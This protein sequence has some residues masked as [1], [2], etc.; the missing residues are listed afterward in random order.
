MVP[1][2]IRPIW[3]DFSCLCYHIVVT[4]QLDLENLFLFITRFGGTTITII[5]FL[6]V[7]YLLWS[8]DRT[9]I[10]YFITLFICNETLVYIIKKV[11]GRERPLGA[12]KYS[13]FGASMP[14]GHAAVAVFLYGYICYLINRFYPKSLWRDLVIIMLVILIFL[15]GISRIYLNVHY[16]SDVLA[17]YILGGTALFYLVR[18]SK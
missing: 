11:V 6:A 10:R 4:Y 14:S 16:P 18:Y 5:V 15:I 12:L 2:L 9:L 3:A 8:K 13:E 7:A 1:S 17:G